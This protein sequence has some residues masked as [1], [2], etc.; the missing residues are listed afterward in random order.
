MRTRKTWLKRMSRI[1][2]V[3]DLIASPQRQQRS[4][5]ARRLRH[6]KR[7]ETIKA[8]HQLYLNLGD[9]GWLTARCG[10]DG[11]HHERMLKINESVSEAVR[12]LE[13]L[14]QQHADID[15]SPTHALTPPG[16]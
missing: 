4:L 1:Y 3:F 2:F 16:E 7:G 11:W 15:A 10:C 6:F 14:F 8:N 9:N 5:L 13:E 12:Q